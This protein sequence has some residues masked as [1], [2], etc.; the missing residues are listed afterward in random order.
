MKRFLISLFFIPSLLLT[1][2]SDK[3]NSKEEQ[4]FP[5]L[6]PLE[7]LE[8]VTYRPSEEVI[9]NPERG[10]FTHQEYA[11][12]NDHAIT[13]E[14]LNE[15]R[16]KGMSLIFTA[17]YMRNFKDKLISE[18]YLQRIRNNMLALRKGGAKCVLRFA[19][20]SSENEKPW[21]APWTLTKQHIQQLKPIFDE[22]SD[23]ICVLEAGFVGVW[24]EWY[25]T[26]HYNYQ[27]K[28]N[29]YGPRR[30]VLDALLKVM[31]KD[32]MISVRYPVAKLFTFNLNH[33]DTITQETAYNGSDLSRISFHNDCFLADT[34]DMGTFGEN[35]DYRKFWEWETKYVAMGGE[36][37]Q[38]SEYSN[39]ENAVTDFAKYHWSYINIDYH[40]AV[41]NQWEDEHCMTEI[42]KRLGYRF[43]LSDGYFTP[44]GKIGHPYEIV[45]KLQNTGW[46]A[47]FNPR[48]VEIIFVHKKKKDNKYKIKL[49]ED[50]R[51]W[52]PEEQITIRVQFGLPT[53]MPS[54]EY[55]IY[56]NLPDP[57]PTISTRWEYSI[58]LANRDVWNKQY[59][60]NKIHNTILI[61]G[62]DGETFDGETLQKF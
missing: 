4:E 12:D 47:P 34:D 28:K 13:P 5:F 30:K 23:V 62:S 20:T 38:L 24:G 41:I 15:Y 6:T 18:E 53:S 1:F 48:D 7:E 39:C 40:P 57:K 31:P 45:L 11:T 35:P 46:A 16:N 9:C 3:V 56:L 17:Y 55:D 14:F 26:D 59:G 51:F 37:C 27:P 8:K 33:T 43:T 19:Y 42:K 52:F 36:T 60:Y 32:R 29:E 2:C 21:D 22:F 54:G 44:K 61:D 25:Y 50:P 58:Q 10:F 49:K